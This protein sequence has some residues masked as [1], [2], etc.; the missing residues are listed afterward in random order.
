MFN[1]GDLLGLPRRNPYKFYE[2]GLSF[3]VLSQEGWKTRAYLQ[4][5]L[6]LAQTFQTHHQGDKK[7]FHEFLPGV[8]I[9]FRC[10]RRHVFLVG[11]SCI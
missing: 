3:D 6:R 11:I 8:T 5:L 10:R 4:R 2:V 7:V 1:V 9:P